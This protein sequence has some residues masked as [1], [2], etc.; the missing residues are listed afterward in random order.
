MAIPQTIVTAKPNH[1]VWW[2]PGAPLKIHL[3]LEVVGRLNGRLSARG[4]ETPDEGILIGHA[5]NGITSIIDFQP[6]GSNPSVPD[7]VASLPSGNR[8]SIVGYYRTHQDSTFR[9]DAKDSALVQQCFANPHQVVL[10]IHRSAFGPPTA[11]FFFHAVNGQMADFAFLEFPFDPAQ[12]EIEESGRLERSHPAVIEEERRNLPPLPS[13]PAGQPDRPKTRLLLNFKYLG[14]AASAVLVLVLGFFLTRWLSHMPRRA[15]GQPQRETV[16]SASSPRSSLSLRATRQNGDL[17]LTWSRESAIVTEATSGVI[18][19]EDGTYKHRIPLDATHVR[20]GNLLYSPLS[21]QITMQLTV[22]GPSGTAGE[23]VLVLMPR[24]GEVKNYPLIKRPVS[25][26]L[27]KTSPPNPQPTPPPRAFVAPPLSKPVPAPVAA[28]TLQDPPVLQISPAEQVRGTSSLARLAMPPPRTPP[29]VQAS[30]LPAAPESGGRSTGSSNRSQIRPAAPGSLN[31][32]P[33]VPVVKVA[34]IFPA[35]L[36]N[37]TVKKIVQIRV[38]IDA[39]GRVTAAEALPQQKV[40][41]SLLNA[42]VHAARFWKFQPA[43]RDHQPVASESTLQF[44][45][46]H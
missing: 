31:Y 17:E 42:A 7:L 43:Q 4:L 19:I 2:F 13:P 40:S 36:R 10:L 28:V 26:E 35:E 5:D 24:M 23:S 37:L 18:S 21:D 34:A 8:R 16:A 12:L 38:S 6:L 29:A 3:D 11:T 20:S 27:P 45:F 25:A 44:V 46:N 9:L 15:Q 41:S 33:P 22:Q 14:L 1:Y 32:D 30:N 39:S